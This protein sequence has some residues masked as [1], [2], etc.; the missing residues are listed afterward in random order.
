MGPS[1]I[2]VSTA[3]PRRIQDDWRIITSLV[4]DGISSNHTR[5]AYSQALEEFLVWFRDDVNREFNKATVQKYRT[6]LSAK[7]LAPPA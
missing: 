4:L 2:T 6:E 5:R 1:A 7:G 3:G